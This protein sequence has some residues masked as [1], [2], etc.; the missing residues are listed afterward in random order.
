MAPGLTLIG[1]IENDAD[2]F[3]NYRIYGTIFLAILGSVVFVGIR[4]V[5]KLAPISLAAVLI[6]V[7]CIYAGIVKSA[8]VPPDLE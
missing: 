3:H 1:D 7:V 5:S 2:S 6:S 8:F 4:F